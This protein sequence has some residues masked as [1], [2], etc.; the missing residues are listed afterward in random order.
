MA[1]D[2]TKSTAGCNC[3]PSAFVPELAANR[4]KVCSGGV[5]VVVLEPA[6]VSLV[7]RLVMTGDDDALERVAVLVGGPAELLLIAIT[8]LS[9]TNVTR[10]LTAPT[11]EPISN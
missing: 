10:E 11:C 3:V 4:E 1:S 2:G 8:G 9:V 5:M 6:L 7:G